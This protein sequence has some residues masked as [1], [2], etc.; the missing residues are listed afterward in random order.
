MVTLKRSQNRNI[1]LAY[2]SIGFIALV[3]GVASVYFRINSVTP[4]LFSLDPTPGPIKT[5]A[6]KRLE[7]LAEMRTLDSDSDGL[8][9]F[10]EEYAFS[11]SA[12]LADTD[13]DGTDDKTEIETGEDPKCAKG[14]VCEQ[15]RA[16]TNVNAVASVSQPLTSLNTDD[17]AVLRD[18][19]QQLG[20]SKAV[21]DSVSDEDLLAVYS[22]V[23]ADFSANA[24]TNAPLNANAN[25]NTN[26]T[27]TDPYAALLP[28]S[29][30]N[31]NSGVASSFNLE[32]FANLKADDIRAMLITSG[33]SA[34]DLEQIDD[35]TLEQMYQQVLAE[36][37]AEQTTT[38]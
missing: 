38:Q 12:Y 36:Q 4:Y 16:T 24:N 32:D 34:E 35:A 22:S 30:A 29:N 7:K 28:A 31:T 18:Q 27:P 37:T 6:Q 11:T 19:L 33:E 25:I 2:L 9:D 5:E 26:V 1:A 15:T 10:D 8:N 23:A 20:I 3:G 21:L 17:P 13:S 14:M